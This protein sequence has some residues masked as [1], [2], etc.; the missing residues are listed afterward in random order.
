[1]ALHG[2]QLRV[3]VKLWIPQIFSC[4][5]SENMQFCFAFYTLVP[6]A[7]LRYSYINSQTWDSLPTSDSPKDKWSLRFLPNIR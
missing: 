6:H 2:F 3:L 4:C 1:M 5:F 7:G